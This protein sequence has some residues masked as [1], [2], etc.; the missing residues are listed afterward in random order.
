MLGDLFKAPKLIRTQKA[1]L[2]VLEMN[3]ALTRDMEHL[4]KN[5]PSSQLFAVSSSDAPEVA[6]LVKDR[7]LDE[8][9]QDLK[10]VLLPEVYQALIM[11]AKE[12]RTDAIPMAKISTN[13]DVIQVTV[14]LPEIRRVIMIPRGLY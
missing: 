11:I 13:T 5:P 14:T 4:E 8:M 10:A 2:D 6:K 1:L 12:H 9:T 3:K 7:V